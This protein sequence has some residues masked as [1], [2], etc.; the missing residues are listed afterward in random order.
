[1]KMC[2][3][4]LIPHIVYGHFLIHQPH[5]QNY[6]KVRRLPELCSLNTNTSPSDGNAY[7]QFIAELKTAESTLDWS[8]AN[9]QKHHILPIHDGGEVKGEVVRC[10]IENHGKA[11]LIRHQVFGQGYDQ[12]A[13][14]FILKQTEEGVKL[15]QELIVKIN[16]ER[17]NGMFNVEWQREQARKPKSSY[18]FQDN[19]EKAKEWSML[20]VL[21]TPKSL[22][23]E[24]ISEEILRLIHK[25]LF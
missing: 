21:P 24:L 17:G 22:K 12:L 5:L 6:T 20:G 13:G 11:H 7:D 4:F 15:R 8:S 25:I 16:R 23:S 1:M 10:T 2:K 19:P 3:S 18:Y 9:V 14:L